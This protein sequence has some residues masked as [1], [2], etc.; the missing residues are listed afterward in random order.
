M[1]LQDLT[2]QLR[3]R[4]NRMERAVGWFIVVATFLLVFGFG[5]YIYNTAEQK[6]WFA[7]KARY[8]TYARSGT[9][10]AVGDHVNLLGFD[11]GRITRIVPMPAWG[12]GEGENVYVEFVVINQKEDYSGYIWTEGSHVKFN[13]TG[14]LGSRQLDLTRGTGGYGTYIPYRV[15]SMSLAEL[16]AADLENLRL[17]E[18]IYDGTNLV[19]KAWVPI[20][21]NLDRIAALAHGN[22]WIIDH[23]KTNRELTAIW[24]A[25]EYHYER[26]TS[27]SKYGLSPEEPPALTDR[28]QSMVAQIQTALPGILQLTNQ[29]STVL[30]NASVLTSN[31]SVVSQDARVA[32]TNLAVITSQLRNPEG[33]LGEWLIPTN[34]NQKLDRT[35]DST[36]RTV[37]NLNTNLVTLNLTLANLAN[38]TSNLNNQVQA[39]TNMLTDISSAVEHSDQFIQGLK[40][41]WLFRHLFVT[42]TSKPPGKPRN[43]HLVSPKDRDH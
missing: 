1:P 8:Y 18:E 17:G 13:D 25:K 33:S 28:M 14:F 35:L 19:L 27:N 7:G 31:L 2:P 21:T 38:I 15:E 6:G 20:S 9:G 12:S 3:T 10:L 37:N 5:F 22:I 11:V 24:N 4:L 40:R 41:F 23:S 32:V 34:L 36:D 29:I 16:K 39:N 43:E 30:S 42:R 26:V